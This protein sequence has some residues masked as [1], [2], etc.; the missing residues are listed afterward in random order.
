MIVFWVNTGTKM[1]MRYAINL[2]FRIAL[3]VQDLELFKRTSELK[4]VIGLHSIQDLD[5]SNMEVLYKCAVV[6]VSTLNYLKK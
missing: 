6:C 3:L 2:R 4:L 5:T 1:L